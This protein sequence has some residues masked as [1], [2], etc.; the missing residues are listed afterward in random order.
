MSK[1]IAPRYWKNE[2]VT[3][4]YYKSIVTGT[5]YT[6]AIATAYECDNGMRIL[7]CYTDI[8]QISIGLPDR[9]PTLEEIQWVRDEFA[10][11]GLQMAI[12]LEPGRG[13][14]GMVTMFELIYLKSP[15]AIDNKSDFEKAINETAEKAR[16]NNPH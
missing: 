1:F 2:A 10:P 12:V 14:D 16:K 6:T 7:V 4:E 11:A 3:S 5:V 13:F 9:L 15:Q 8:L